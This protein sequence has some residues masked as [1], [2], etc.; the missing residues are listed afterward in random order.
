M[1]LTKEEI[2]V[3]IT[4]SRAL[5][6]DAVGII[7]TEGVTT[8]QG[9]LAIALIYDIGSQLIRTQDP[10]VKFPSPERVFSIISKM[11]EEPPAGSY[12]VKKSELN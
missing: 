8:R 4:V 6:L 5:A 10:V 9:I 1:K 7:S 12:P 2:E 3:D 11:A